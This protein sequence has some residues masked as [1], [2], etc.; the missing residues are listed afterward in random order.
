MELQCG[1]CEEMFEAQRRSAKYCSDRCRQL[2][3]RRGRGSSSE[4][5]GLVGSVRSE[6]EAAKAADTFAGQLALE[7]AK[8]M[9]S[10]GET[11]ISSLS[12]ELRTVMAAALEG[13]TPAAAEVEDEVDK[14]RQARERKAREAAG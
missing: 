11:G 12:K 4:A 8:R 1:T 3:S 6:L 7:L 10:P 14:A 13:K 5:G 2:A 9:S